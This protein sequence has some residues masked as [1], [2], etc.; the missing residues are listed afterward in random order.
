MISGRHGQ[1]VRGQ[2]SSVGVILVFAIVIAGA[3]VVVAAGG[4]GLLDI[5]SQSELE[6]AENSM[7]LFDSRAAMVALGD[8]D[9]QTI[10]MVQDGG[11]AYVDENSGWLRITHKN[12]TGESDDHVETIY[13]SSLGRVVYENGDSVIAYQGGGVWQ[14][15]PGGEA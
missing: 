3:S 6:R 4:A 1:T 9:I 10:N 7:T 5:Q 14:L 8:S 13:N 15:D 11:S 2:S 12:Y